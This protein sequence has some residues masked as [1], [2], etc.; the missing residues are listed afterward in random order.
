MTFSH[1]L[2]YLHSFPSFYCLIVLSDPFRTT[3]NKE[4][5]LGHCFVPGPEGHAAVCHHSSVWLLMAAMNWWV[6]RQT[7]GCYIEQ[8]R[9]KSLFS[10]SKQT[11]GGRAVLKAP[12]FSRGPGPFNHQGP[13]HIPRTSAG[14]PR[15][16][17]KGR[18]WVWH[19]QCADTSCLG[20]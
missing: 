18:G 7:Q 11:W 15:A 5:V 6:M 19:K 2:K 17:E 9:P 12:G 10:H 1:I 8:R 16:L 4:V 13:C 20:A 14:F 3:S